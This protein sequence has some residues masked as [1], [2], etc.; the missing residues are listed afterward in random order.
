MGRYNE[1]VDW[2]PIHVRIVLDEEKILL[3]VCACRLSSGLD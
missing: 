1:G 3:F 2:I